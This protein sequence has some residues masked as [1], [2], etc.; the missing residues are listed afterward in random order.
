MERA[1]LRRQESAKEPDT[2]DMYDSES[3]ESTDQE[4]GGLKL[5]TPNQIFSTLPIS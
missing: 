3:E 2:A 1:K 5:L 4:G